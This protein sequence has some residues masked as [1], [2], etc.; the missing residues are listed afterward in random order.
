[1]D[2]IGALLP[3]LGL[4]LLFTVVIRALVLADRRER[5]ARA[6]E[7]ADEA[8]AAKAARRSEPDESH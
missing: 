8:R 1:M 4:A 2:V 7:D 3:P 5:L 6:R